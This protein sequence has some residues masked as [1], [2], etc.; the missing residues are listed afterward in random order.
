MSNI[1][2]YK[3]FEL[4]SQISKKTL[5]SLILTVI[6]DE[7]TS[8]QIRC[9]ATDHCRPLHD[10]GPNAPIVGKELVVQSS[11]VTRHEQRVT[12]GHDYSDCERDQMDDHY[13][14][15]REAVRHQSD[16]ENDR[17]SVVNC[18]SPNA[19][20]R[21]FALLFAAQIAIRS[22]LLIA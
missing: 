10:C 4:N 8:E 7:I 5:N 2:N 13:N 11:P 17:Q 14:A 18:E 9:E 12:D 16:Y 20:I 6:P 1:E 3:N 15:V 22:A 19:I 21:E